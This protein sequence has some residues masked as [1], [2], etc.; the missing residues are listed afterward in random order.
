MK[1]WFNR[2]R[3]RVAVDYQKRMVWTCL[4]RQDFI[5]VS[6][7]EVVLAKARLILCRMPEVVTPILAGSFLLSL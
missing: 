4:A 1:N 6:W 5:E 2:T 7:R 3:V